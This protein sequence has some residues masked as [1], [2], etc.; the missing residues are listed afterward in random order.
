MGVVGKPDSVVGGFTAE[1][2]RM[3]AAI[4]PPATSAKVQKTAYN[5]GLVSVHNRAFSHQRFHRVA[6]RAGPRARGGRLLCP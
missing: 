6:G 2:V 1:A 3:A 5:G 4:D